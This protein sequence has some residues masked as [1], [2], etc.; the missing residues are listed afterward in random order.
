MRKLILLAGIGLL[1]SFAF[2]TSSGDTVYV[3]M[4]P[5]AKKFHYSKSCPGL[6]KCTHEIKETTKV[7]A[8]KSG[9]TVCLKE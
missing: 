7:S 2:H 8:E 4:S 1:G 9:Y 6:Q 5:N 3:C